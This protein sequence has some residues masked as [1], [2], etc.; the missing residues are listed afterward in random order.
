MK[1]ITLVKTTVGLFVTSGLL[2][3]FAWGAESNLGIILGWLLVFPVF[4]FSAMGLIALGVAAVIR[5][6]TRPAETAGD[7][8]EDETVEAAPAPR[9]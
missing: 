4:W 7:E 2:M 3:P 9:Q 1:F 8:L 6:S 5:A